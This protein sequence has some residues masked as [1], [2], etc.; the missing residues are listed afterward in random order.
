MNNT[1]QTTGWRVAALL[2]ANFFLCTSASAGPILQ[3]QHNG[4]VQIL[5]ATPVG[6]TFIAEDAAIGSIG[7]F[8]EN[9]N[10]SSAPTD[11]DLTVAL[12]A[13]DAGAVGTAIKTTTVGNIG[14]T[15]AGWV[16][17]DFPG[18]LLTIGAKYSAMLIND[19]PRW[20]LRINQHTYGGGN[21]PI[22]GRIDYTGGDWIE[23]G[24]TNPLFDATFRV[25]PAASIPE[26]ATVLLVGLGLLMS[27]ANRGT[28]RAPRRFP[29]NTT[30]N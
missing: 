15:S 22:P 25:L 18:V 2:A 11:L 14:V 26:P 30:F 7:F 21:G 1:M 28:S 19:T 6:Q 20:G 8:I 23:L 12:Y 27:F 13:G 17:F 16:D 9:I 4:L 24:N 29:R 10:S 3:P 5:I